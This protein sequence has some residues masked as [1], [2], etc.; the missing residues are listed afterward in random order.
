MRP[1]LA[2]NHLGLAQLYRRTGNRREAKDHLSTAMAWFHQMD[3]QFW[4][5]QAEE[6]LKGMGGLFI[7]AASNLDLYDYL[8][9]R[10]SGEGKGTVLLNR[11]RGER[12]QRVQ[13]LRPER[14]R[15]DRRTSPGIS[16]SAGSA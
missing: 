16:V 6:E 9:Q 14:R 3:M 10:F 1:L 4:L 2:R 8:R 12:R 7:V 15:G 13:A 11:R 5:E